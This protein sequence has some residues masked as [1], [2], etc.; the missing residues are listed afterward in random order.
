[1]KAPE[2][3]ETPR[4]VLRKPTSTDADGI[5]ARYAGDAEVTRFLSWRRHVS[6]GETRAFI[7][8]SDTQWRDHA[9]GPYL[10][11]SHTGVLLGGTGLEC[12]GVDEATTG[13]VLARDA[14]GMGYA[15]E[16]LEAMIHIA[17]EIDLRDL[18]AIC[19]AGHAASQRVLEKCGFR[20]KG[21]LLADFPNLSGGGSRAAAFR[22]ALAV[23]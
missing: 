23:R 16:A 19:H 6:V 22:Y 12:R 10:I 2:R 15:T 13:Y 8:F 7:E 17:R 11:E 21:R 9:A 18:Y 4:L 1:M 14:W 3:F 20:C 5:F